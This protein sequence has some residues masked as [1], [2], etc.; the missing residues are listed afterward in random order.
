MRVRYMTLSA[1]LDTLIAEAAT[2][3]RRIAW[4]ELTQAEYDVLRSELSTR[5]R[6][7]NSGD[8]VPKYNGIEIKVVE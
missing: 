1:Q 8:R 7:E 3:D 6:F 5:L 2:Q 4:F